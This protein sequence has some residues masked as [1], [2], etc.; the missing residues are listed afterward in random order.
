MRSASST[1]P[2]S[3]KNTI[4]TQAQGGYLQHTT[5]LG[6]ANVLPGTFLWILS[7]LLSISDDAAFSTIVSVL[8]FVVYPHATT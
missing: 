6:R 7:R 1:E 4:H 5:S 8:K 2:A 3:E